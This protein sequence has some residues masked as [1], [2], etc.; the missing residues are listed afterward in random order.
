MKKEILNPILEAGDFF[1]IDDNPQ[2][3]EDQSGLKVSVVSELYGAVFQAKEVVGEYVAARLIERGEDSS[4][5]GVVYSINWR[6]HKVSI[7]TPSYAE[8]ISNSRKIDQRSDFLEEL[9]R[10][11]FEDAKKGPSALRRFEDDDFEDTE[12]S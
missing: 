7:V 2:E 1:V 3:I 12:L 9:E 6:R 5:P 4:K 8:A 10:E 11:F